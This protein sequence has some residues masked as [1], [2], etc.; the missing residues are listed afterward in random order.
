MTVPLIKFQEKVIV[1]NF[2]QKGFSVLQ[3]HRFQ[4]DEHVKSK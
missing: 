3:V 2:V 1:A 4:T